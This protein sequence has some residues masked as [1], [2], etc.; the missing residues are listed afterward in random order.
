LDLSDADKALLDMR[1]SRLEVLQ[2]RT[3]DSAASADKLLQIGFGFLGAATAVILAQRHYAGLLLVG[4]I[5]G[6][7]ITYQGQLYSNLWATAWDSQQLMKAIEMQLGCPPFPADSGIS[8][9]GRANPS[10]P[11]LQCTVLAAYVAATIA[12]YVVLISGSYSYWLAIMYTIFSSLGAL[13]VLFMLRE[14]GT[15]FE[16]A[17]LLDS[18]RSQDYEAVTDEL[19]QALGLPGVFWVA[20][21]RRVLRV[22]RKGR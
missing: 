12:G 11:L 10:V 1:A 22:F 8:R 18:I 4:P 6:F 17:E 14:K 15:G 19:V 3:L 20:T 16:R 9:H 13:S 7:L 21:R 2:G 5:L